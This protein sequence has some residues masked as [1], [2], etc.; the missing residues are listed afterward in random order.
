VT[1]R[2]VVDFADT[3]IRMLHP[4]TSKTV[5]VGTW[6]TRHVVT[7]APETLA[8]AAAALMAT[9]GVS[10]VP[11]VTGDGSVVGVLSRKELLRAC[12]RGIDPTSPRARAMGFVD[13]AIGAVMTRPAVV[14]ESDAPL[15]DAVWIMREQG[16]DALPVVRSGKLV[17]ILSQD[18]VA[19]ALSEM[20]AAAGAR[21]RGRLVR[22]VTAE[23]PEDPDLEEKIAAECTGSNV[24]LRSLV[25]IAQEGKRLVVMSVRGEPLEPLI[26]RLWAL[27]CRILHV[28]R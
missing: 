24:E 6:M 12:P 21:R 5:I 14:I 19:R 15:D 10:R 25:R 13:F 4:N 9:R 1:A 11:V 22:R 26:E 18:D 7:V 8:S 28:S 20:T 3:W 23:A 16:H 17:G 27:G 2:C